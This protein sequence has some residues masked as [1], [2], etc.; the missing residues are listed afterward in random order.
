[1]QI[2]EL[3]HCIDVERLGVCRRISGVHTVSN[4]VSIITFQSIPYLFVEGILNT[5]S[6]ITWKKKLQ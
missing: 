6:L 2:R 1:M 3:E 4:M 5:Q